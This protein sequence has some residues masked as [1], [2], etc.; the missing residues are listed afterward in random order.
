VSDMTDQLLGTVEVR[1]EGGYL[2]DSARAYRVL[3][4]GAVTGTI[5]AGANLAVAVRPGEHRVDLKLDWY[6]S[7]PLRL[8][9]EPGQTVHLMSRPARGARALLALVY[10]RLPYIDVHRVEASED[11]ATMDGEAG[12]EARAVRKTLTR[13]LV[14]WTLVTAAVAVVVSAFGLSPLATGGV[15]AASGFLL[16]L[17]LARR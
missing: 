14:A 4:D 15:T 7:N 1:R 17:Y 3:I 5:S 8:S 9:V 2:R 6:R 13:V 10:P 11:D 16:L 12:G